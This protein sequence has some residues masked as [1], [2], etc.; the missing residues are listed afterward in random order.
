MSDYDLLLQDTGETTTGRWA[1]VTQASPL[2]VK[3]DGDTS[4]LGFTPDSLVSN[5][6]VSDRVWVQVYKRRLVIVGKS[7][8]AGLLGPYP[9]GAIYMSVVS[10]SPATLFGGTWSALQDRF[11]VGAGGTYAVNATGGEATHVLTTAE[12]PAHQHVIQTNFSSGTTAHGHNSGGNKVADASSV[13]N[14]TA[15]DHLTNSAGSDGAHNNLPPYLAVYMWKR[16]A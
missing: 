11:L 7:G 6:A 3:I 12:M 10:T 1:T 16:T 5:L 9:V 14:G 8:G 13:Q 15:S 2:R 4:A